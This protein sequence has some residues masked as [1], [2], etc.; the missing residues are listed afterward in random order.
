MRPRALGLVCAGSIVLLPAVQ[1]AE[2]VLAEGGRATVVVRVADDAIPAERNAAA[3]L[4]T[5]LGRASGTTFRVLDERDAPDA[6]ATIDVGPTRR[7]RA[8][9]PGIEAFSAERWGIR[10]ERGT[11]LLYGG[12][13]R[14]TLYAVYRFL[15]DEIGVRFWTPWDEHVPSRPRLAVGSIERSGEPAFVYRDVSGVAG[16]I[17]YR[18]RRRHNGHESWL[19]AAW[20][21]R[22]GYGP[23]GPVH[24]AFAYVPPDE[25]FDAHPEFFSEIDGLRYADGQLCPTDPGVFELVRQRLAAFVRQARQ[26]A[27]RQGEPA[28][29]LFDLS[30]NDWGRHCRCPR[31]AELIARE[32]SPAAPW[33]V[34]L[35]R[36][37]AWSEVE[38]PGIRLDTL[39]YQFTFEPPR[40]LTLDDRVVVRVSALHDRDFAKPLDDPTNAAAARAILGWRARSRHTRVWDYALLFGDEGELPLPNLAVLADDLRWYREIGVEGVFLQ[41][42]DPLGSD[43]WDLKIWVV[44]QLLE[45]P[46]Q[47]VRSLVR[48][49]TTGY[50]GEAAPA[51]RAYLRALERALARRPAEL[52][53]RPRPQA[54]A[55]L[56]APLV[57][58]SHRRFDEAQRSVAGNPTRLR[59]VRHARL[60]LDR[61]T[62]A[63]W[64]ELSRDEVAGPALTA[65]VDRRAVARRFRATWRAEAERRLGA[66]AVAPILAEVDRQLAYWDARGVDTSRPIAEPERGRQ[67][68]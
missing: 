35:N 49:F 12:R 36:L 51:V 3:E 4:A 21:G 67:E 46:G 48:D 40:T 63:L 37:A 6:R 19:S 62:L 7:T 26:D 52:R 38:L 53:Y 1:A 18:A 59:R 17:V 47:E 44:S 11:V 29:T 8:A 50:Y 20:G 15:E 43:L 66:A 41:L 34:L 30:Q 5:Y 22:E 64:P 27:E 42:E 2:T 65:A 24:T 60:A 61:A 25:L 57:L 10:A 39:A 54:Y 31:C 16:P 45:D 32:G 68:P 13:P 9:I 55:Y 28:P 56:D 33:V 23:P 58:A 14:G